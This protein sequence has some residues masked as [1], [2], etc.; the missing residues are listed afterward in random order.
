M[1]KTL[2]QLLEFVA[3]S[4]PKFINLHGVRMDPK[5]RR[6]LY[7]MGGTKDTK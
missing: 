6:P 7:P 5:K 4:A 1:A 3:Q 2:I